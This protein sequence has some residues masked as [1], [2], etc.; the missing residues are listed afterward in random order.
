MSNL[1]ELIL[2]D[3]P[4]D[5]LLISRI[6]I[7]YDQEIN[8]N[9]QKLFYCYLSILK[10]HKDLFLDYCKN[11]KNLDKDKLKEVPIGIVHRNLIKI[12]VDKPEITD[13]IQTLLLN[14]QLKLEEDNVIYTLLMTILDNRQKN[15]SN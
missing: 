15:D 10:N 9:P 11:T 5:Q 1:Y 14:K 7:L 12:V 13:F 6:R 2:K 3:D 4:S 8:K